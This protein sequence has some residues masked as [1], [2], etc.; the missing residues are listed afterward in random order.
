MRFRKSIK[1]AP[2]LKINLSNSGISTSIGPKGATVNLKPGR[3]TR[4]TAGIPGTGLSKSVTLGDQPQQHDTPVAVYEGPP[5]PL[6]K[7]G[8]RI[9]WQVIVAVGTALLVVLGVVLAII[10][11]GGSSKKR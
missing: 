11:L 9:S 1:L 6:W 2:G 5:P 3:K 10:T 7:S 8:L 4:F